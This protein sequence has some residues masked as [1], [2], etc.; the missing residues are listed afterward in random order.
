MG[1]ATLSLSQVSVTTY[2]NDTQRTG[3]N[4]LETTLTPSNVNPNSFGLLF[5]LPVDGFVY[6]QPLYL[7]SVSIPG[8]GTHNVLYI[9]TEHNSVY[10][11]DADSNQ[12]SNAQPLWHVNLGPSV[13]NGDT[14]SGDIYPEIGITGTPVIL[15]AVQGVRGS[16]ATIYLVSKTK[17]FDANGNPVYTQKLHAL[18]AT[19]GAEKLNGPVTIQASVPGVGDGTDGTGHVPF[20]ALI[21]HNRSALLA[22]GAPVLSGGGS[23][24]SN[25]VLPPL[26]ATP[27]IYMA[28]ASHGDN[29]PYHG[30][31]FGYNANTL[32][33][34][35]VVNTTP[36]AKTDPSGYP[37]A[38]GG[39]WQSGGGIASDGSNIF[40]ATGNGTF[41]PS[42][43]SYG[44]SILRI[45]TPGL[46]I[47]D[48]FTPADQQT[49]DD[50]DEDLGSGAVMLLPSS[51]GSS[52][53][54][55]LLV[56]CG[57]EGSIYLV[58]RNSLGKNGTTDHVVQELPYTMGGIWGAPAYFNGNIY[59][60]PIYGSL[61]AFPI[62]NASFT[63]NGAA[64]WS[65]TYYGYPG[66]TPSVSANG[67][68]NGIVWAL[69]NDG[70]GPNGTA[71]LHAYLASN[72]GTELY[73]S[74]ATNGRDLLGG[75]VKFS[76][77]TIAN[78]KVYCGNAYSVSVLGLGK[79]AATPTVTP[80][81]GNYPN[82]VTVTV[83]DSTPNAVVY[84]TTDG[85][86]PTQSSNA[87]SGPVTFNSSLT[88]TAKAFAPGYGPSAQTQD[89]YQINAVIG[90]GTGLLG[91][92]YNNYTDPS[93]PLPGT[94]T[95]S[96]LDP[97]INFNWNGGS[98]IAG[99]G[100]DN[101]AAEW[102]GQVQAETSS[103]YT[104]STY[105][106]DGVRV[107][108]NGQE[109]I[110]DWTYHAPTWDSGTITLT[111]GQKYSIV[112]DYFQG[113]GGS[114]L[115]L[116]WSAPGMPFQLVP[117]TQLYPAAH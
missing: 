67:T 25:I 29:G 6:A 107:W 71:V 28:F 116:D 27:T 3:L 31:L 22:L 110:N 115:Q 4:S 76:T 33:Q 10:A 26:G 106:D 37:L 92:Y 38:A 86:T 9:A 60:G 17:T 63:N 111:G 5:S 65:P 42:N 74:S 13:P 47:A 34:T 93:Q 57:K 39:I 84:Y 104:F 81:S 62:A 16:T 112:I 70:S 14:G 77:P 53:Y 56:Q 18:D 75:L 66:P 19:T 91:N 51:V 2:H 113:G 48:Y 108:V 69:Q 97:L 46:N 1:M 64:A 40:L 99:V 12:G 8:K 21:Q 101:W 80:A 54:P 7:P 78:G 100:G 41:N 96:E 20:N 83:T 89:N 15:P 114:L 11:F 109:I 90:N 95:N 50:Y 88:F 49:L 85:S 72:I 98:P 73:N 82:S 94:P 36:N 103:T 52:T 44:D 43:G 32:A 24:S 79:W 117:T 102:K 55:S 68:N 87:Y 30:W 23:S 35:A 59:Y 45:T 105:S 58:N 61:L